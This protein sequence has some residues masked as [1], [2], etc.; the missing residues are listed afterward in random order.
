M[1][2][3]NQHAARLISPGRFEKGSFRTIKLTSGVTA[4]I[5]R[6]KG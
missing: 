6:L 3:P 2:F 5:G 1:P 4:I